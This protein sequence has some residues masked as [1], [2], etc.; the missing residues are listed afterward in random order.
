MSVS[1]IV[2]STISPNVND[3]FDVV[4]DRPYSENFGAARI[5]NS[6]GIDDCLAFF[7]AVEGA[8]SNFVPTG[9]AA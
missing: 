3:P 7:V 2:G 8:I 6:A 4:I 9:M 1:Y 5:A